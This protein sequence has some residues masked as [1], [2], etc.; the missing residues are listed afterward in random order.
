M[1]NISRRFGLTLPNFR[2][3]EPII[4]AAVECHPQPIECDWI[5]SDLRYS[6]YTSRLRDAIKFVREQPV[7][8]LWMTPDLFLRLKT[9]EVRDHPTLTGR[10]LVGD[11]ESIKPALRASNVGNPVVASLVAKYTTSLSPLDA[12]S[13]VLQPER[14]SSSSLAT[15]DAAPQA[16]MLETSMDLNMLLRAVKAYA[17]M[18]SCGVK[19]LQILQIPKPRDVSPAWTVNDWHSELLR[20]ISDCI[21]GYDVVLRDE[22]DKYVIF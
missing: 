7:T 16:L 11:H 1:S 15:S 4:R 2:R 22:A 19:G 14:Q 18:V 3:F 9:L 10:L 13:H 5:N 21:D 6:T 12:P 8:A 17:E 20:L